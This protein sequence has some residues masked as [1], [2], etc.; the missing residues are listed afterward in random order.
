MYQQNRA[1]A[2]NLLK[3]KTIHKFSRSFSLSHHKLHLL[4]YLK[5]EIIDTWNG[6][7]FMWTGSWLHGTS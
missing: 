6:K 3:T 1:S 4:K 7:K 5:A 2:R